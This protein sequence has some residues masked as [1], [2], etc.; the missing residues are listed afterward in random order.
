MSQGQIGGMVQRSWLRQSF[1]ISKKIL[2]LKAFK[3][4]AN[5]VAIGIHWKSELEPIK[6]A[7]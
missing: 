1:G 2:L 5:L 3:L 4:K 7:I 6:L